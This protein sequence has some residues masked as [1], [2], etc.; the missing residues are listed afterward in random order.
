MGSLHRGISPDHPGWRAKRGTC[1]WCGE[2]V[3]PPRR[4]FCG[5]FCVEQWKIRNNPGYARDRVFGRD[6]GVCRRCGRDCRALETKLTQLLYTDRQE[7]DRELAR[8]GLTRLGYGEE[9]DRRMPPH[10][11]G[12]MGLPIDPTLKTWDPRKSLWEADHVVGVAE[13]GGS[14]GLDNLQTLCRWCHADKTAEQAKRRSKKAL[15]PPE[16]FFGDKVVYPFST[17]DLHGA[18]VRCPFGD[19]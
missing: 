2:P 3:E 16:D 14:C 18:R 19:D 8:L 13:G 17:D 11:Q 6:H 9:L 7:L 10:V 4:T 5:D 15:E 12:R 1:R